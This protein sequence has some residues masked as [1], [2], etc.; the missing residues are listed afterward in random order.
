MENNFYD[1]VRRAVCQ[2]C[3]DNFCKA[4]GRE[5]DLLYCI[6]KAVRCWEER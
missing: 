4:A 3:D 2:N 6:A 5:Q 1:D